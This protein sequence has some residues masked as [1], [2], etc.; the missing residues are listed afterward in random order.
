MTSTA[1]IRIVLIDPPSG[2]RFAVQRGRDELLAP[3]QTTTDRIIFELALKVLDASCQPPRFGGPYVHG[4]SAARFVYVNSGSYAGEAGTC[5]SRR[6]KL[7]LKDITAELLQSLAAGDE[8]LLQAEIAGRA[9]DGGPACATVPLLR[10]WQRL[11]R[12]QAIAV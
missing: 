4:P 5:W 6:I 2:V 10:P 9:R 1:A 7:P 8:Y 12:T 11:V 3:V